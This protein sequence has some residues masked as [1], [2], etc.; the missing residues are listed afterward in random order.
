MR[1]RVVCVGRLKRGFYADGCRHYAD[2]LATLA[3][4]EVV[5]LKET[6][7]S[8]PASVRA[9]ESEALLD[10]AA[11][12]VVAIDE[13]GRS[14]TTRRLAAHIGELELRGESRISLLVGGADGHAPWL[15]ERADEVW[16]LSNLT[17]AHEL[18]RLVLLEQLYRLETVRAGHPYHRG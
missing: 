7:G 18:A 14:F 3:K 17:L 10:A 11:G 13:R 1:Y 9:A 15:R 2:R 4:L 16:R 8:D 6:R 5:E 12:R